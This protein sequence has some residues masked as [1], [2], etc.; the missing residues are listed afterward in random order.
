MA[1]ATGKRQPGK[2][3]DAQRNIAAILD[4]ALTCLSRNPEASIGAIAQTAGVGRVTLY[5]HFAS[6]GELV[7]AVVIR[8][9]AD[10]DT[11]LQAVDL[12]GDPSEALRRLIESSWQQVDQVRSVLVAAQRTLADALR[13]L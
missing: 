5:G 12:T 13:F 10:G 4:A 9:I 2:R 11:R 8:A 7:D 1:T 3:A 6:R